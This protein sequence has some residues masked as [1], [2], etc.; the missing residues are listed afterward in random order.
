MPQ[1]RPLANREGLF[2]GISSGATVAAALSIADDAPKGAVILAMLPDT[3]ER[4]LST[5]PVRRCAGRARTTSG[6][7]LLDEEQTAESGSGSSLT[8]RK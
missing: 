8:P 5:F 1:A 2:V 7:H 4:Y 3:G 6:S